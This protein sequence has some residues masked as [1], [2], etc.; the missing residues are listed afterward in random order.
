[1][2]NGNENIHK[3][4]EAID[5]TPGLQGGFIWEWLNQVA[6]ILFFKDISMFSTFFGDMGRMVC[7]TIHSFIFNSN[8]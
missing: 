3:Y 8:P 2:G 6:L 7:A 5:S 1:M 4:W